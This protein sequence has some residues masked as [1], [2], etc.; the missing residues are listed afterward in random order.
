[1]C[2]PKQVSWEH[3]DAALSFYGGLSESSG[4]LPRELFGTITKLCLRV[5]PDEDRDRQ[6]E[7][8]TRA[9]IM[10]NFRRK[11]EMGHATLADLLLQACT[12]STVSGQQLKSTDP[13]DM[14]FAF[15]GLSKDS[16]QLDIF[17]NYRMSCGAIF[18]EVTGALLEAGHLPILSLCS[19]NG[20]M[21][22]LPSWVPRF[23][24]GALMPMACSS[25]D[26]SK[27]SRASPQLIDLG[28]GRRLLS[29]AAK[30]IGGISALAHSLQEVAKPKVAERYRF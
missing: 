5:V 7:P 19:Q 17:P 1:M 3:M 23:H 13:R 25:F 20:K 28:D 26:A 14:V 11:Q 6:R 16:K 4:M 27:Q 24:Y 2:G 21:P 8:D 10:A 22:E 15:L 29:L 30:R 9:Y 12:I 18:T